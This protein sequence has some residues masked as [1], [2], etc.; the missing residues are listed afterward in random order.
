MKNA[1]KKHWPL[2]LI[3]PL[4]FSALLTSFIKHH[5]IPLLSGQY[6]APYLLAN[7]YIVFLGVMIGIV[8]I[9][10]QTLLRVLGCTII[11]LLFIFSQL[12]TSSAFVGMMQ[13]SYG[14]YLSGLGLFFVMLLMIVFLTRK[15]I[16]K[17]LFIFFLLVWFGS[18]FTS[19]SAFVL[20]HKNN[21]TQ[22]NNK[23]LPPYIHIV[24]D[25]HIGFNRLSEDRP[26]L[27]ENLKKDYIS[28]DFTLYPAAYSRF[29]STANSFAAFMNFDPT[30]MPMQHYTIQNSRVVLL[31]NALFSQLH[32]Q[33]YRL[34]VIQPNYIEFCDKTV[35]ECITYKHSLPFII[36][37]SLSL[38]QQTRF[39]LLQVLASGQLT[40]LFDEW[41]TK[42]F[43]WVFKLNI[44]QNITSASATM[45]V[46]P[47]INET[48]S[49]VQP[50]NAY[51]IHLLLPHMPY[52]FNESC[53][54]IHNQPQNKRT[55][56]QQLRCT[57]KKLKQLL[58]TLSANKNAKE[59]IIIIHG[60]HGM[61]IHR[62][63]LSDLNKM[64][65]KRLKDSFNT[66]YMSKGVKTTPGIQPSLSP[67]YPLIKAN[68][69]Q[70][71]P[72]LGVQ[73]EH[74]VY[75]STKPDLRVYKIHW[76]QPKTVKKLMPTKINK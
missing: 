56:Y 52:V 75:V 48:F 17:P 64:N 41:E 24:L 32:M 25:E 35:S 21:A 70:K 31:N 63:S 71:T 4:F 61:K 39:L 44:H 5:N 43:K 12:N 46:L 73:K 9:L 13:F 6:L 54:Y 33:G 74:F 22:S 60:D 72:L 50:G 65:L 53:K 67:L 66:L 40:S 42:W 30:P 15:H 36:D 37:A 18:F 47:L 2:L 51:F 7:A 28:R 14:A 20:I 34:H 10:G 69:Q 19:P 38:N 55:Y 62:D 29:F 27:A 3:T 26:K 23:T 1:F 76:P 59:A 45:K 8:M 16:D 11:L 58:D 57:H 68:S 49:K